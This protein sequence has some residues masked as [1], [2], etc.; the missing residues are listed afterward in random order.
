MDIDALPVT[1]SERE[2]AY[3]GVIAAARRRPFAYGVHDCCTFAADCLH[4]RTGFD[5]LL[6]LPAWRSQDEALALIAGMGGLRS[7]V[8]QAL[9]SEPLEPGFASTGDIVLAI[10]PHDASAREILAVAHGAELLAPAARGLAVLPRSA[11][12]CC[13]KAVRGG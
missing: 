12:L 2:A 13:W 9:Q 7:A 10:D 5:A 4:A 3:A 8:T 6:A 11:A 1:A